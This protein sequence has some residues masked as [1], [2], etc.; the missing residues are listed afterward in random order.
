[1]VKVIEDKVGEGLSDALCRIGHDADQIDSLHEMLGPFCHESRN[2]LNSLKM[3]LYLARKNDSQDIAIAWDEVDRCYKDVERL[4]ER[5]QTICRPMR[6]NR[7]RLSLSL[8]LEDRRRPWLETFA[9]KRRTLELVVPNRLEEGEYAPQC[10]GQALDAFVAWRA[11]AVDCGS[12]A[13]LEASA[14][15]GQYFLEWVE[16]GRHTANE[17]SQ[18]ATTRRG[19]P[20]AMPLLDRVVTAHGGSIEQIE[21]GGKHLRMSWPQGAGRPR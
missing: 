21:P 3:S 18:D 14:R 13:R 11:N 8:L 1:M 4:F 7:V 15:G 6:L 10:L 20:L 12:S 16:Q 9:G 19:E 5:L 2:I 17:G